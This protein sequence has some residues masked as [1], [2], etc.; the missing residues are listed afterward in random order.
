[1]RWFNLKN[2]LILHTGGTI[3]MSEDQN[4]AVSPDSSN[5]LNQFANPF[6]G[7]LNLIT[8]DIFNYPSPHIGPKQ[9]LLL[10]KEFYVLL[11]KTL[12]VLLSL[13]VQILLKKLLIFWI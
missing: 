13:T 12:M 4:G 11:M 3:A 8:E 10:E 6:A 5:P 2:I 1:M 7:K 9:M